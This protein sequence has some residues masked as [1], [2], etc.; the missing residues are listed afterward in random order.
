MQ[1][2]CYLNARSKCNLYALRIR[3][4]HGYYNQARKLD[5]KNENSKLEICK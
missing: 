2:Q 4:G 1:N 5:P 3:K